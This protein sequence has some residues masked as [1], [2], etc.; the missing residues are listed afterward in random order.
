MVSAAISIKFFPEM[1]NAMDIYGVC[2]L[3]VG[4]AIFNC[5]LGAFTIPD[6]RGKSLVK[7]EENYEKKRGYDNSIE[8]TD[9]WYSKIKKKLKSHRESVNSPTLG[10]TWIQDVLEKDARQRP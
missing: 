4:F 1:K 7:V 3:N 8:V 10:L 5:I 9:L 2:F 6:N